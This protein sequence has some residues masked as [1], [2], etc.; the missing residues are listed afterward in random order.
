[1]QPY[2]NS[3]AVQMRAAGI[4]VEVMGHASISKLVRNAQKAKTP[5]MCVVGAKEVEAHSLSVRLHGATE[6]IGP[7]PVDTVISRICMAVAS[8]LPSF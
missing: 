4:R 5:M 8:K 6:D 3:V 7:L 1:M 2:A